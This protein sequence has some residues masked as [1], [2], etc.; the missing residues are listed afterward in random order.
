MRTGGFF[1]I[2]SVIGASVCILFSVAVTHVSAIS[3]PSSTT[4][5][6]Q[7]LTGEITPQ[8]TLFPSSRNVGDLITIDGS[9]FAANQRIIFKLDGSVLFVFRTDGD[10][11]IEVITDQWDEDS[12]NN[13]VDNPSGSLGSV[14]APSISFLIPSLVEGSHVFSAEDEAGN[15][16]QATLIV[17]A[18]IIVTPVTGQAGA[19]INVYGTGLKSGI[20]VKITL[21][22]MPVVGGMVIT[23]AGGIFVTTI[24]IPNIQKGIYT[25]KVDFGAAPAEFRF[26]V[27]GDVPPTPNLLLPKEGSFSQ[28]PANFAWESV[29]DS[30]GVTYELQVSD[31]P[32]FGKLLLDKKDLDGPE[33]WLTEAEKLKLSSHGNVFFRNVFYWR[34]RAKDSLGIGG[35]WSSVWTY[36]IS[37]T[38]SIWLT[39]MSYI[40]FVGMLI[41]AI[42]WLRDMQNKRKSPRL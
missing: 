31:D 12:P 9:G 16:A 5:L 30:S 24:E 25:V 11:R 40:L 28:Q 33:Y 19:H 3:I 18:N 13:P 37:K 22:N 21:D 14:L 36:D 1:R 7:P 39:Y 41:T 15:F 26:T 6:L 38:W 10:G 32:K 42:L 8:L 4:G 23:D 29:S 27:E 20:P 35:D 34:V 2:A 17:N